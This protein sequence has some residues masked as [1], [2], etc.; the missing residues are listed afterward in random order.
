MSDFEVINI[1]DMIESVGEDVTKSILSEFS[2]SRNKE[3]ERFVRQNAIEFAKKKMSVTYLVYDENVSLAAIFTL[4]HKALEISDVGLSETV[5]KKL[6]RFSTLDKSKDSYN[7]SAFLIGQFGKNDNYSGDVLSGVNLMDF[8]FGVL[9]KVQ[10]DIGGSIVYLDC[11]E[12][13]KLLNFYTKEPNLFRPFGDTYSEIDNTKYIQLLK[14][15]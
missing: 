4:A 11:E 1:L 12:N 7:V 9:L 6:R 14:F 15:I 10:H 8:T 3:I 5:R 2:C 13:E